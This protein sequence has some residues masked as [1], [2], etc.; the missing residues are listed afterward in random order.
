MG[1]AVLQQVNN[2]DLVWQLNSL[3]RFQAASELI[4]RF[5]NKLCIYSSGRKQLYSN[6]SLFFPEDQSK[7]MVVLPDP[8]A[9][10][11][12]FSQIPS[13]AVQAT[14]LHLISGE[15]INRPGLYLI[16]KCKKTG[17][18][19]TPIEFTEGIRH[20]YKRFAHQD[21]FL[22]VLMQGDL[23]EFDEQTPC[24]HLHRL[25]LPQLFQLSPQEKQHLKNVIT[26]KVISVYQNYIGTSD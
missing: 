16:M 11:D 18:Q 1:Y 4:K 14:G 22:P 5:E 3:H 7:S 26:Y 20:L 25:R 24:I 15:T 21:P 19:S 12:V 13:C 10:Q 6:Y 23:T 17:K 9:F 2:V 8:Y